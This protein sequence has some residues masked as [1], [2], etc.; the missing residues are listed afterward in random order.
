MQRRIEVSRFLRCFGS[1][2]LV[3][4]DGPAQRFYFLD[5]TSAK[6]PEVHEAR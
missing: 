1:G 3:G 5:L 4:L 2:R 6:V